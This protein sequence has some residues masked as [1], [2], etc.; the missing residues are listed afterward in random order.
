M[1]S[2]LIAEL[3]TQLF[4]IPLLVFF[5][6][7]GAIIPYEVSD[8]ALHVFTLF[9]SK[10]GIA[11]RTAKSE[12]GRRVTF[13]G[14]EG[15]FPCEADNYTLSARLT[16]DKAEAW[17]GQISSFPK[18]VRSTQGAWGSSSESWASPRQICS[19]NS[20]VPK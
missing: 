20:P 1:F 11:L 7:F 12:V 19:A 6:D 10:L 5:G 3:F 2:R 16:S 8:A 13:L 17:A 18:R 15:D 4:G 9:C 14:L